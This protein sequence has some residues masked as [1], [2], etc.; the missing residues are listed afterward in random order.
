[1]LISSPK[2]FLVF[3]KLLSGYQTHQLWGRHHRFAD[4]PRSSSSA[5]IDPDDRDRVGL[6]N[7]GVWP[8]I[9]S[10]KAVQWIFS[11][12][13]LHILHIPC[14]IVLETR[15]FL[16]KLSSNFMYVRPGVWHLKLSSLK[17]CPKQLRCTLHVVA[18]CFLSFRFNII[19]AQCFS[20]FL[21]VWIC[22]L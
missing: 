19:V 2:L 7:V 1:M 5:I 8:I 9:Y 20:W 3:T 6:G 12:R 13:K 10:P 16:L 22:C 14:I 11:P 21:P 18:V 15:I 17:L 4:P